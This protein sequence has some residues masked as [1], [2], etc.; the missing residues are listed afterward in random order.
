M[1]HLN[2]QSNGVY[3]E[4]KEIHYPTADYKGFFHAWE[5]PECHTL[6]FEEEDADPREVGIYVECSSCGWKGKVE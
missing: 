3:D 6:S 4:E 2:S 5:C 1:N